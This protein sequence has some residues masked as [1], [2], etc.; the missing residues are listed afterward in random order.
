MTGAA[1]SPQESA[2]YSKVVPGKGKSIDLNLATIQGALNYANNYVEGAVR[3]KTGEGGVYIKQ[4]AEGAKSSDAPA[5][6]GGDLKS[7]VAEQGYD[8][9][10]M[11]ADGHSDEEIRAA[12][13]I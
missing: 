7:Q 10:Q 11:I 5:S 12:L 4:Y 8:Y 2:E 1:F 13:G 9:D 3:T 6:S